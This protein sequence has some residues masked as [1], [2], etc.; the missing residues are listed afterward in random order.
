MPSVIVDGKRN[1]RR[2]SVSIPEFLYQLFVVSCGS[3]EKSRKIVREQILQGANS[4][5]IQSYILT[6][7]VKPV[8]LAQLHNDS[9]IQSDI[10][11]Y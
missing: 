11:D 8:L 6:C 4:E 10:E 7:I 5:A 9:E 1:G 3:A 2:V